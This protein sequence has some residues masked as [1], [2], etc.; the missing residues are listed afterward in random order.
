M[1]FLSSSQHLQLQPLLSLTKLVYKGSW[2]LP[3]TSL[4][5]L[6]TFCILHDFIHFYYFLG[7][8]SCIIVAGGKR[9][10]D[11]S[12]TV[13]ILT[14]TNARPINYETLQQ[15]ITLEGWAGL[16]FTGTFQNILSHLPVQVF[17]PSMV[18]HNGTILLCGGRKNEKR[19]LL[20]YKGFWK[21]HSTLNMPRVGHSAVTTQTAT[22][23]FG[24]FDSKITYEYLPKDSTKWLKGKAEIPGGF[25]AGCAIAA[26][27]GKEIWLIG[28]AASEK[29]IL[30]FNIDNHTFESI[31]SQLN[32]RR[33]GH[34]CAFIPNTNKILITG[35]FHGSSCL[36]STEILDIDDGSVTM[37]SPLNFKRYGHSIGAVTI[38]AEDKLAV[39]GG[40]DGYNGS[41]GIYHRAELY[42]TQS[43]E[44]EITNAFPVVKKARFGFLSVTLADIFF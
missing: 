25:R 3:Q 44:W 10:I 16:L 18:L 30:K 15:I 1:Q 36:N 28:G 23:V 14:E 8:I 37:A 22:Y 20:L 11:A 9:G 4:E 17:S 5:F 39:F 38:N 31:P 13:E 33:R 42:N 24:G 27:S 29:R 7:K 12:S 41:D 32:V 26:K 40:K 21:E 34:R 19:C 2:W 35:G 43:K 6:D